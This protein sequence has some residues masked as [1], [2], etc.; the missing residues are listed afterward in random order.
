MQSYGKDRKRWPSP[1]MVANLIE[2][3]TNARLQA[4]KILPF[5]IQGTWK[6]EVYGASKC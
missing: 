6:L 2:K 1:W 4:T 5:T 3:Y